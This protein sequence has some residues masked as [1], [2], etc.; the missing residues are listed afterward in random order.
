MGSLP[1]RILMVHIDR[2]LISKLTEH[3]NPWK[4]YVDDT[5]SIIK[6]T[7]TAHVLTVLNNF[8]KNIE[9]TRKVEENGKIAFLDVL[10]IRNNNALK[11][12]I[13]RKHTIDFIYIGNLLSHRFENVAYYI[14]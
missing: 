3:M 9:F 11:S 14:Q 2:T 6:E 8:H 12:T 10:I 1:A 5:T 4:R 7:S 13:C